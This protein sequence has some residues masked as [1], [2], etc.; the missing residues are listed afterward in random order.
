MEAYNDGDMELPNAEKSINL[1]CMSIVQ[2][3]RNTNCTTFGFWIKF[4]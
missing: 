3:M 2:S 4:Q 1:Y